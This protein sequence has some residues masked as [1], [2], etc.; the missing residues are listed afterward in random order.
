MMARVYGG[1]LDGRPRSFTPP[2]QQQRWEAYVD[3]MRRI[4]RRHFPV[5]APPHAEN[6]N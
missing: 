5:P 6:D 4:Y 1:P 3:T 2:T